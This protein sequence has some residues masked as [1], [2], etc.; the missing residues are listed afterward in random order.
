M[1]T[2]KRLFLWGTPALL[3]LQLASCCKIFDRGSGDETPQN[4]GPD[5]VTGNLPP[6][7]NG[8]LAD[9]GFRPNKDGYNFENGGNARSPKTPGFVSPAEMIRLFGAK[10][11]CIGG[12]ATG[13]NCRMTP[14]AAEF[15]RKVNVS[16]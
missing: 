12:R 7:R 8:F 13:N 9:L 2:L 1:H 16:M 15:A 4:D 11:V 10:D 6:P 14:S 3:S 5:P